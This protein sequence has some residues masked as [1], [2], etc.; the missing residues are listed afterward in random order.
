MPDATVSVLTPIITKACCR[1]AC[2]SLGAL[3]VCRLAHRLSYGH[4]F[5]ADRVVDPAQSQLYPSNPL[6][7]D[8]TYPAGV[9]G[10]AAGTYAVSYDLITLGFAV[11]R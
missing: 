1:W 11:T 5:Q 2:S 9:G 6:R 8:A 3:P 10:T 7:P 4:I